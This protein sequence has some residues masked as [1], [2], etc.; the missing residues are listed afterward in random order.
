MDMG[1]ATAGDLAV[2][3]FSSGS[4]GCHHGSPFVGADRNSSGDC[5]ASAFFNVRITSVFEGVK[6][7]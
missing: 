5:I 1:M 7:Q 3:E 4:S 6:P 2:F